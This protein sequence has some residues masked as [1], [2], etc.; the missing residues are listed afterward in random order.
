[1]SMPPLIAVIGPVEPDLLTAFVNHYRTLGVTRFLTAVH[2]PGGT[3]P[4]RC[5][6]LLAR[7]Q[8]LLGPPALHSRG[9]WHEHTNT[10]L[11]DRL[12]EQAGPGWHLL[13]DIDELQTW[14]APLSD[15]LTAAAA[16][17]A[18]AS[19]SPRSSV[20]GCCSTASP[21]TAP[22]PRGPSPRAWTG[23]TRWAGS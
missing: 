15:S 18:R 19:A 3:D 2:F 11:R 20:A 17:G 10:L 9:P 21:A 12:R 5:H 8:T 13:A 14:P 1:M 22:Y 7:H 6:A 16:A 23:P 4:A